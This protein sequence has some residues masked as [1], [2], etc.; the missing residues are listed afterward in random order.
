MTVINNSNNMRTYPIENKNDI[1][2]FILNIATV[3]II[4]HNFL[5][6]PSDQWMFLIEK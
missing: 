1:Q 5:N 2:P 4:I 3:N 6:C